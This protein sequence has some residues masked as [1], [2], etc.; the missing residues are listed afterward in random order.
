LGKASNAVQIL[1]KVMKELGLKR[2]K[3]SKSQSWYLWGIAKSRFLANN[4]DIQRSLPNA[5]E[6]ESSDPLL[7]YRI[8]T[9][10]VDGKKSRD[11]E[12]AII[13]GMVGWEVYRQ[14]KKVRNLILYLQTLL[15]RDDLIK[16]RGL[17]TQSP[18]RRVGTLSS[19][20]LREIGR[21]VRSRGNR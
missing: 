3:H 20:Q 4:P 7:H 17:L 14:R 12:E 15:P 16:L 10:S 6:Y 13:N 19:Y 5:K 11:G 9:H 8:G 21:L 18:K 2:D 1:E